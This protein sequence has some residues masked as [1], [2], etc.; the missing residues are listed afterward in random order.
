[1]PNEFE[2]L[3]QQ[4]MD[5]LKLVP[6]EPVWQK[7]EMQ[8][9][10]KKDRRRLIF[11]IPFL[12]LMLGGGLWIGM[13]QYSKQVSYN[14]NK[15]PVNKIDHKN[16]D[17]N[18][19]TTPTTTTNSVTN[20]NVDEKNP[21]SINP[22]SKSKPLP[23]ENTKKIT[24]PKNTGIDFSN[25]PGVQKTVSKKTEKAKAELINNK[26]ASTSKLKEWE[27]NKTPSN[28]VV[29]SQ[30]PIEKKPK[31]AVPN[32]DVVRTDTISSVAF[33]GKKNDPIIS[34]VD[35]VKSDSLSVKDS[36][37]KQD[38]VAIKKANTKKYASS[39]WKLNLVAAAGSSTSS[40]FDLFSSVFGSGEK[41][42]SAPSYNNSSP[43]S[44]TSGS[45]NYG[46]SSVKEGFSFAVGAVAKKQIGNRVFFSTGLRYNYYSNTIQVG[47]KINQ[48]RVLMDFAV[49][50]YY[51][52]AG[53]S[54]QPYKNR[55]HFISLPATMEFQLLKKR[56]LN[57]D[58]G[59]SLQYLFKTN[60]LVFD[61][62]TQS[63]F[64]NK[65]AF[66]RLQLFFE[67]ALTYSVSL[68][69]SE[70]SFGPLLQYGFSRL[71]KNSSNYRITSYGLKAQLQFGKK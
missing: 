64:S 12:G 63:Y 5:E 54:L 2:K 11:W 52:N 36:T 70:L 31:E 58:A 18:S 43:G 25:N 38:T 68:K 9:R 37:Q 23:T 24:Q 28:D 7:V 61:Y 57:F 51:T 41:S 13:N 62:S 44:V 66:N 50:Q 14:E 27:L 32:L 40:D 59:L 29:N 69:Q 48:N 67:P 46:P 53:T 8:I 1:M 33:E 34:V 22:N 71:E 17:H 10:K 4:K 35:S 49:S 47:N 45:F 15:N 19:L 60:G 21:K 39:K 30:A 65:N 42:L 26:K 3:V 6:S 16:S 56:P 20:K 55:Y